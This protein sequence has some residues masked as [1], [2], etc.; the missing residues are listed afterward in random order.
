MQQCCF[1]NNEE[2]W[3]SR[4]TKPWTGW[5]DTWTGVQTFLLPTSSTLALWSTQL[6][7]QRKTRG[8]FP[9]PSGGTHDMIYLTAIG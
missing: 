9:G 1:Y 7:I 5:P 8:H 3:L 2:S 6:P 4:V